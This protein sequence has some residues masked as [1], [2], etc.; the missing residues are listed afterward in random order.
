MSQQTGNLPTKEDKRRAITD[1]IKALP[2]NIINQVGAIRAVK[3]EQDE[4]VLDIGFKAVSSSNNNSLLEFVAQI[5]PGI[6]Y[7]CRILFAFYST[8]DN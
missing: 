1:A 4:D 8:D 2:S 6:V 5:A 7:Y 3:S